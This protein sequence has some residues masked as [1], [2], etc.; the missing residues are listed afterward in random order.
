MGDFTN[1]KIEEWSTAATDLLRKISE[2]TSRVP[3]NLYQELR[4][5]RPTYNLEVV[6]LRKNP[7]TGEREVF[8]IDGK[9]REDVYKDHTF[10]VGAFPEYGHTDDQVFSAMEKK[11]R[12]KFSERPIETGSFNN[13][14]EWM[15]H[16]RHIVHLGRLSKV[17]SGCPGQWF[18]LSELPENLIPYHK[19][20]IKLTLSFI[21]KKN[22]I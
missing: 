20:I 21:D 2:A 12:I 13:P 22:N 8:L 4:H 7:E 17:S 9:D 6:C 1:K 15:G 19:E 16:T 10:L 14:S 5:I 3:F 11:L 18:T